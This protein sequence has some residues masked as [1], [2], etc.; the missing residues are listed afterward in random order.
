MLSVTQMDFKMKGLFILICAFV[1]LAA[2][3]QRRMLVNGWKHTN[4]VG[5]YWKINLADQYQDPVSSPVGWET[6]VNSGG[7]AVTTAGGIN[8][9]NLNDSDGNTSTV[10]F[11]NVTALNG[12]RSVPSQGSN[13]GVFPDFIETQGWEF[14]NAGQ[15]KFTGLDNS[16]QYTVYVHANAQTWEAGTISFTVGATTSAQISTSANVGGSTYPNWESDPALIKIQ[17]ITP[18]SSAIT[19]TVNVVSGIGMV[20]GIVLKQQ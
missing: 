14:P 9:T 16:K 6:I 7:T 13:V 4:S 11:T 5:T 3:S 12:T 17:N 1:T 19:I 10:G 15:V 18:T 2:H 8:V 20:D